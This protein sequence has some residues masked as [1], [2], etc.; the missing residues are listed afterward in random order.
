M[1]IIYAKDC[2]LSTVKCKI[3]HF[4][5]DRLKLARERAGLTQ[6]DLAEKSGVSMRSIAGWE[7][8]DGEPSAD[9]LRAICSTLHEPFASF[10]IED[11][12]TP[13]LRDQPGE[14]ELDI[15]RRRAIQAEQTVHSLRTGLRSLLDSSS[16]APQPPA[17]PVSSESPDPIA[18]HA[19]AAYDARTR[20]NPRQ[21]S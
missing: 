9:K 15:W 1:C 6:K 4:S 8:G 17:A 5:F 14:S 10:Y 19:E 21:H 18:E 7:S 11:E 16:P 12:T 2:T 20:K 3:M 13:T